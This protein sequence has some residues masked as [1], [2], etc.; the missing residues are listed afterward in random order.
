MFCA[1]TMTYLEYAV[2]LH[3][4]FNNR[5]VFTNEEI[6]DLR[7]V[8]FGSVDLLPEPKAAWLCS[9]HLP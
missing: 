8:L 6:Q 5:K 9:P 4:F 2:T 1:S 3:T 7:G